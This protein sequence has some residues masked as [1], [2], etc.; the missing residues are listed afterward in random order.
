MQEKPTFSL[1]PVRQFILLVLLLAGVHPAPAQRLPTWKWTAQAGGPDWTLISNMTHDK[2]GNIIVVGE[3]F[4]PTAFGSATFTSTPTA[5]PF[6]FSH[7]DIFIA[8]YTASGKLRWVRMAGGPGYDFPS[9][10]TADSDGSVYVTG[11]FGAGGTTRNLSAA[12]GSVSLISRGAG[13]AFLAKY[14]ST[15]QLRW[16]RQV[17]RSTNNNFSQGTHVAVDAKHN[18]YWAGGYSGTV[19]IA[20][21]PASGVGDHAVYLAKLTSSGTVKWLRSGMCQ[22]ASAHLAIDSQDQVYFAGNMVGTATFDS[23]V[24][25]DFSGG[26]TNDVFIAKY[27]SLGRV[28]WAKQ[29]GGNQDDG[30]VDIVAMPNRNIQV[31]INFAGTAN[32]TTQQL[33]S[34]GSVNIALACFTGAGQLAWL[35]Q[36]GTGP[37]AF[38]LDLAIDGHSNSYTASRFNEPTSSDAGIYT[39]LI[40]YDSIGNRKWAIPAPSFNLGWVGG[41]MRNVTALSPEKVIVGGS[42]KGIATFPGLPPITSSSPAT[43]T[44]P[45][46]INLWL[47]ELS[48][49]SS[50]TAGDFPAGNAEKIQIP[51]I[52]TPNGDALN[53][54]FILKG[55]DAASYALTIYSRWGMQLYHTTSYKQDWNAQGLPSGLYYYYLQ[56]A[57]KATLK[58][59]IEVTR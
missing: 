53:E 35:R 18:V 41:D 21:V 7:S 12:F 47:A 28:Q 22:G 36:E 31:A 46:Q 9:Q 54:Y 59:W 14:D 42:F 4:G 57:G 49:I 50:S 10:V 11:Q 25:R 32:F 55:V 8:K 15:G 43:P 34:R 6:P 13:E 5:I 45:G 30:L 44:Y 27:D 1:G 16:V 39:Y 56:A 38:G 52:I 58:G 33:T 2:Q 20:G 3:F 19:T 23:Y 29:L 24:F 26:Y 48:G 17:D 51:N 40:A 37:T